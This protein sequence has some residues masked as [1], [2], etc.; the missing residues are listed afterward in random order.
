MNRAD[1]PPHQDWQPESGTDDIVAGIDDLDQCIR[2]ILGPPQGFLSAAT[3]TATSIGRRI[4][5][6]RTWCG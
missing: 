5:S 4:A 6:L 2:L 1:R 3:A